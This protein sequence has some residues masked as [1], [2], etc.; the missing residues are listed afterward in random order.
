MAKGYLKI[1]TFFLFHHLGGGGGFEGALSIY[2]TLRTAG[3][4]L[5]K[6]A[7]AIYT[8]FFKLCSI[9]CWQKGV[10]DR[11]TLREFLKTLAKRCM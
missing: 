6:K 3:G 4:L 9:I 7:G 5:F 8:S 2:P 11:Y 10:F 1:W